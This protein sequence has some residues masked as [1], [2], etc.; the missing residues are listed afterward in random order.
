MPV[1][2]RLHA[3]CVPVPTIEAIVGGPNPEGSAALCPTIT[4][5]TVSVTVRLFTVAVPELVTTTWYVTGSPTPGDAG[6][7]FMDTVRPA[8]GGW[9]VYPTGAP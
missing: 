6:V 8:T 4:G 2:A 9:T 3:Y 7:W 1:A 5:D